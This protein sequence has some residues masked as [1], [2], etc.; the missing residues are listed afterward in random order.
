MSVHQLPK[1]SWIFWASDFPHIQASLR[2]KINPAWPGRVY[3]VF[4]GIVL[5]KAFCSKFCPSS[6]ISRPGSCLLLE[7]TTRAM[8]RKFKAYACQTRQKK[9]E[10]VSFEQGSSSA[11]DHSAFSLVMSCLWARNSLDVWERMDVL[12]DRY[13]VLSWTLSRTGTCGRG[14][15]SRNLH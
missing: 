15:D 9:W 12:E 2:S 11:S 13:S 6:F 14:E 10:D 1:L 5:L 8:V 3:L 4:D 7:V